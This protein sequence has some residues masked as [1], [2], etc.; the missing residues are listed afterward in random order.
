MFPIQYSW[1]ECSVVLRIPLKRSQRSRITQE[2][3]RTFFF[4]CSQHLLYSVCEISPWT[5]LKVSETENNWLQ[6]LISSN[7]FRNNS[8]VYV[9]FLPFKSLWSMDVNMILCVGFNIYWNIYI[10]IEIETSKPQVIKHP[11][12]MI[13]NKCKTHYT[14][15]TYDQL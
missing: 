9:Q 1:W 13:I 12:N 10:I 14:P 6:C 4:L 2:H 15:Q 8:P 3:I 11:L 5:P 7:I